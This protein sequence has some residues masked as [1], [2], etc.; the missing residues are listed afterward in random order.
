MS[1][2]G[3]Q[4]IP[5]PKGVTVT[6]EPTRIH[7]KGPKGELERPLNRFVRVEQRDGQLIVERTGETRQHRAMHGL[8]RSLIANMVHGVSE[9]W[10]KRL[11]VVGTGYRAQVQGRTLQL[12]VGYSHPVS[13]SIPEGI[14]VTVESPITIGQGPG[15]APAIPIVVSGID[16]EL[17]GET[18]AAIRRIKKPEPYVP[19]KGI[20]YENERVRNLPKKVRV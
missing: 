6:I 7:V 20:R 3:R 11:L 9:G 14:T 8:M 2:I 15:S 10:S 19:S 4:P 5:I 12:N 1:R 13:F 17:V 18:A 16:K